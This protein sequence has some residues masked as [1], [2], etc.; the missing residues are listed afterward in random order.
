VAKECGS[1]RKAWSDVT[2]IR[3][4]ASEKGLIVSF[5]EEAN[6][7]YLHNKTIFHKAIYVQGK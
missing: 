4:R 2:L 3:N 6:H 1:L 7:P 5:V